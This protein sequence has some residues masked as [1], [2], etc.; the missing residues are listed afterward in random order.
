MD[1][2][3]VALQVASELLTPLAAYTVHPAGIATEDFTATPVPHRL[4]VNYTPVRRVISIER[5]LED[6]LVELDTVWTLTGNDIRFP[7]TRSV[8]GLLCEPSRYGETLRV[9]YQFGSTITY[10]ARRAVITLAHQIW[11]EAAGCDECGECELPG[12]TTSV[13]REGI[14]YTI[15]DPQDYLRDGKTGLPSVDLWI[16]TANPRRALR[17]SAVYTPDSPPP[18]NVSVQTVRPVWVAGV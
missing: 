14:S 15:L 10:S 11:L 13:Q 9:T 7:R 16:S 12:R 2:I 3:T 8:I 5:V 17:P 18:S 6:E 4:S 1:L